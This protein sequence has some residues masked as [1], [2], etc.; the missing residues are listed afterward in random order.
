MIKKLATQKN[1]VGKNA[2]PFRVRLKANAQFMT[3]RPSKVPIHFR[4]KL[5][6]FPKELEKHNIKKQ[7]GFTPHDK[8]KYET[9][10]VILLIVIELIIPFDRVLKTIEMTMINEK[11]TQD[12]NLNK[13][14]LYSPYV[15]IP[16]NGQKG[17]TIDQINTPIDTVVELL[18]EI[19]TIPGTMLHKTDIALRL[20]ID[21]FMNEVLLLN[22]IHALD[23]ISG[24]K[25]LDLIVALIDLIDHLTEGIFVTEKDR[26]QIQEKIHIQDVLLLLDLLRDQEILKIP[27]LVHTLTHDMNSM[28]FKRKHQTTASILKC[29]CTILQK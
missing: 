14:F 9:T 12:Q 17:M 1:N 15:T 24:N 19:S 3:Q 27:D 20:E 18:H 4:E 6:T 10:Y 21:T 26:V 22:V 11:H 29:T 5:N 28:Q 23:M 2:T 13:N 25:V 8:P 16:K 7:I